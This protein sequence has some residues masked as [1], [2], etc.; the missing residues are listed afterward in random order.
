MTEE[1]KKVKIKRKRGKKKSKAEPK[2]E[3]VENAADNKEEPE[4]P[5]GM[6]TNE[7]L[8]LIGQDIID[9]LPHPIQ[10]LFADKEDD[11]MDLTDDETIED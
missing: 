7:Q 6:L 11:E 9:N 2:S 4:E 10:N 8:E 1:D 5:V 3:I